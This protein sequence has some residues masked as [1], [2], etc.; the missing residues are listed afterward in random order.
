MEAANVNA[1][2]LLKQ[3]QAA[4]ARA[5]GEPIP[6]GFKT[7]MEWAD[8]WNVARHTARRHCEEGARIGI[9]ERREFKQ[10][11]GNS[12]R[13]VAYFKPTGKKAG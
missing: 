7:V 12:V 9:L 4:S 2:A 5:K 1:N 8:A 3:I 10:H 13:T 11:V 6:Q